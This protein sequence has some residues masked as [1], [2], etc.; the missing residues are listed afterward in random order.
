MWVPRTP[1]RSDFCGCPPCPLCYDWATEPPAGRVQDAWVQEIISGMTKFTGDV[2]EGKKPTESE[3]ETLQKAA[4]KI[5]VANLNADR[6][7]SD[8]LRE[9]DQAQNTQRQMDALLAAKRREAAAP[10][11]LNTVVLD[12]RDLSYVE[13]EERRKKQ[14][15]PEPLTIVW[16]RNP[17]GRFDEFLRKQITEDF[18][19][20]TGMPSF[21]GLDPAIKLPD[22]TATQIQTD[23]DRRRIQAEEDAKK[24][25]KV[26]AREAV[27]R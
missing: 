14:P 23:K 22:Q 19:K 25:M 9:A 24:R 4:E 21:F 3:K 11:L 6:I 20:I 5:H 16:G 17:Y 10:K 26:A 15:M 18:Q 13:E 27:R 1:K 8:Q 12:G 7:Y 2:L